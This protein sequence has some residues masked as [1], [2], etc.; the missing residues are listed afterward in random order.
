[1]KRHIPNI[2]TC[3]NIICGFVGITQAFSTT[4][5]GLLV[6]CYLVGVAAI[7]DFIDGMSARLLGAYSDLGKQLDSLA[8]MISFG[9]LPGI[10]MYKLL[11]TTAPPGSMLP[12]A[13][14]VI[15]LFSALRLAKFNL[16]DDQD[17]S[18]IGLPT[19]AHAV[20]IASLPLAGYQ[21]I[22]FNLLVNP[23]ALALLSG[24]T[25]LLLVSRIPMFSLKMKSAGWSENRNQYLSIIAAL[26]I[27][28][29]FHFIG[30]T[31]VII[32][33]ILTS[34]FKSIIKTS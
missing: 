18:F 17:G 23:E 13:A 34:L 5:N 20:F 14:T 7:F 21:H 33:Y 6:A 22:E 3:L 16:D 10:I 15:P 26:I 1:M 30:F 25:S 29:V 4:E 27:I 19:P 2:F 8:D 31:I 24:I 28:S 11:L 12:Y 9:L 32:L